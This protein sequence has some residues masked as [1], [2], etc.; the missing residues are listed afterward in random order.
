MSNA[1]FLRG[2]A[3]AAA[4]AA[5]IV[6]ASWAGAGAKVSASALRFPAGERGETLLGVGSGE[7][8]P[9]LNG[10]AEEIY[11]DTAY[12]ATSIAPAQQRGA[13]KAAKKLA[14]LN[15]GQTTPW[16]ELGPSGV[17][18]SATVAGESTGSSLG[19]TYSGRTT[20]LAVSPSCTAGSCPMLI[21]AAGGGV[22]ATSDALASSVSWHSSNTGI[23]SNAI[24]SIAFDPSNPS[25]VYVG[26]GEPNGSGDSEAGV[27]LYKSTDGGSTWTLVSGSTAATAPCASNPASLT[28][29]VS[30]GRSIGAIAVDPANP[31]HIL[32]GTDVARPGSSS[33]NGGRF[34]PPGSAQVGL[35]ESTDGGASF[36]PVL[37]LPQD[38]VNPGSSNG[39]DFFRG[40]VSNIQLYRAGSE[41]QVYASAFDYGLF[42]RSQ[43]L[44][45]DS[46][47]H[48]VF[49][50]GGGGTVAGSSFSRTEFSLA[51]NGSSLR[52]YVGDANA[53][54][55]GQLYRV[56]NANVAAS[57]LVSNG[58]NV[59]WTSL[60]NSGKGSAGFSSYNFCEGQ[61]SYDMPVYSPPGSPNI[62]Y[63]GGAMH[64]EELFTA[65]R[66]SNGRGVMRSQDA[67]V[68]FT[69]M[70]QAD[71]NPTAQSSGLSIHPDQHALVTPPGMPNTLFIAD[72]GGVFRVNGDTAGFTNASSQCSGR[73]LNGNDLS[74]CQAWLAK[75]PTSITSL[76]NGLAT[77]QFQS[78]SYDPSNPLGTL[79][80]GTQDNGTQL[81][82]GG[83]W[84]VNVFGDGGQ[85]G[86]SPF[87]S[88]VR[89]HNYFEAQP[90]INFH[91]DSETGWDFIGQSLFEVEPQS[92]YIPMIFDPTVNGT[93]F[94]G[95]DYVWRTTDNG[96]N[97]ALLDQNCNELTGTF[98]TGFTCGDW[99]RLENINSTYALGNGSHWGTDKAAGGYVVA[100][101]RAPSDNGTLWVGTRRGRVF[102]ASNAN[103]SD[104]NTVDFHRIDTSAQPTRFVSG[105]AV[106]PSNPDHAFISYSGYNAYASAA[107][108]ATGHLFEVTYNPAT[109]TATWSSDLAGGLGDQPLTDVAV[110][111][112]TGNIYVSTDFGVYVR[113]AHKTTWQ[114]AASGLPPVAV[115]GLT[116]NVGSRVLYAATHGRGIWK[117]NLG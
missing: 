48:Q 66:P 108:T 41:T 37:I 107:G 4:L 35:Y 56:D 31:N 88:N 94:A 101:E 72:D 68:D 112:K 7:A 86:I 14:G 53:N 93:I 12:P 47:F 54:G 29:S 105:I 19:T 70:T 110:D 64:Y 83:N 113:P 59:G 95:L 6:S 117:L 44:D 9:L 57:K 115:Y 111:W 28:C 8:S 58:N 98:P 55:L 63:I 69:D 102:V 82:S 67:G 92:F 13:E 5:V 25:V 109:H 40:G 16:Q 17:P 18:A 97:Q 51:P 60:S 21:G 96:G 65:H 84:S 71:S 24:G 34:T 22:W 90:D 49:F 27:G 104:P 1:R 62:V 2:F 74:D 15:P 43:T 103:A 116:I 11:S 26:T 39:G 30:T 42:R 79:L 91:G 52:I 78:L 10:P 46:S 32:I 45:G 33:A 87:N 100:T 75:I 114:P 61:C 20:A 81:L 99:V 106:D 85:S 73:G 36:S 38:T 3:V 89:F 80:G 76:N 50:S 77:L 23:P